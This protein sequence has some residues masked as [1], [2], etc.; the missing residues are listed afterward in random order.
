MILAK[1]ND[2]IIIWYLIG[3]ESHNKEMIM[4]NDYIIIWYLIGSESHNKEMIMHAL[5]RKII[6]KCWTFII[7]WS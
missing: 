7:R 2:Y 1:K 6:W 4:K 3:S 5:L